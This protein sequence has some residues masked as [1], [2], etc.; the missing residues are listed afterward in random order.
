MSR[1]NKSEIT[2]EKKYNYFNRY[3]YNKK[4]DNE[5]LKLINENLKQKM[6]TYESQYKGLFSFLEKSLEKFFK[7][8]EKKN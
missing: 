5:K 7:D 2:Q 1:R 4:E 3:A 8:V 6:Y